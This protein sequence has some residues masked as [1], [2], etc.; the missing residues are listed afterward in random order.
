[1]TYVDIKAAAFDSVDREAIWKALQT[2]HV[3][4]F[5]I[6]L[7]KDLHTG[8]RSCLRVGRS[9][10]ASFPTSSGV[11]QGC[12]LAPAMFRIAIDWI[13]SMCADKPDVNVG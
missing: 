12:V 9:C 2:K 4:P 3:P 13:M 6:S 10:T 1:V 7:I 5:L 8:T 11:Q